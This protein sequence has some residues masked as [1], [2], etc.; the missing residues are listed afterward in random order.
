MTLPVTH[1]VTPYNFPGQL[2]L[3]LLEDSSDKRH[4]TLVVTSI[5][6]LYTLQL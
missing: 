5:S 3:A 2:T 4:S 1:D 6:M